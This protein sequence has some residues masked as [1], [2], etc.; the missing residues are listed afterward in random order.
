MKVWQ[1]RKSFIFTYL[2]MSAKWTLPWWKTKEK[3][4]TWLKESLY[5][6]H[7]S[8]LSMNMFQDIPGEDDIKLSNVA[9]IIDIVQ[10]KLYVILFW[11]V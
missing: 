1:L 9:N 5:I 8:F 2:L 11:M 7:K 10:D 6:V 3:F 4:P